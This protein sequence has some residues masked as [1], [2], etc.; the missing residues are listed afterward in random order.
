M[1]DAPTMDTR[2]NTQ[3]RNLHLGLALGLLAVLYVAAVIVFII[4][5]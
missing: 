2:A 5:K 1:I 3:K 4:I